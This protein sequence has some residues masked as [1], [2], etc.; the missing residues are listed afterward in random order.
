MNNVSF[1]L[2]PP[3]F[4]KYFGGE[5]LT[6][7]MLKIFIDQINLYT[8]TEFEN[9]YIG[10]Y[11]SDFFKNMGRNENNFINGRYLIGI[12][13]SC[14]NDNCNNL[15]VNCTT[16]ND[17]T[18]WEIIPYGYDDL[19]FVKMFETQE[20][21]K[22]YIKFKEY[23]FS[24]VWEN[25]NHRIERLC[26]EYITKY[27]TKTND[28][29]RGVEFGHMYNKKRGY[30]RTYNKIIT[31]YYYDSNT[32]NISDGN[33]SGYRKVDLKWDGETLESA[34]SSLEIFVE[35]ELVFNSAWQEPYGI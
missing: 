5:F 23:Y 10:N 35:S 4:A 20:Y 13:S 7:P 17:I 14:L 19:V 33:Y 6:E 3:H 11:V 25:K 29:I 30:E 8:F 22:E 32:I 27:K 34:L 1:D 15:F 26:N 21:L 9:R 12:C 18:K 16:K 24:Y 28:N 2:D 31:V